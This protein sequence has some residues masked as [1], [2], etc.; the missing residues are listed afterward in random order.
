MEKEKNILL[1][2]YEQLDKEQQD[3]IR[4]YL[5]DKNLESLSRSFD[6]IIEGTNNENK[7]N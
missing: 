4:D 1:N 2:F 7:E 6:Q 3:L 5:R